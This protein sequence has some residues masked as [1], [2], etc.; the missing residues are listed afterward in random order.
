[1]RT[2]LTLRPQQRGAKQQLAQ[3]GSRLVCVRYRY[4]EQQK[5]RFKTVELIIE[6]SP[7]DPDGN[8]RQ[9]DSVVPLRIAVTEL[10]VRRQVKNAGGQWNPHRGVWEVR[11]DRVKA[12]GLTDRI[13][14]DREGS[15]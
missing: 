2:R 1:M 11:Y 3:Y 9:A 5:K 4:D 10:A 13:V 12:L 6:E 15:I 14:E 8:Q 7:W